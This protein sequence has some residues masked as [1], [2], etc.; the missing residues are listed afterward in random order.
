MPHYTPREDETERYSDRPR[1]GNCAH[2]FLQNPKEE[3][4]CAK[5]RN[6]RWRKRTGMRYCSSYEPPIEY[7]DYLLK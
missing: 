6:I 3:W 5:G 2:L 4:G 1:C 7:P